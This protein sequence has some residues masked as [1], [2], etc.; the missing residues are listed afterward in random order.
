MLE[1]AP[2]RLRIWR[3]GLAVFHRRLD[4]VE[5]TAIRA[6]AR[7]EGFADV[8]AAAARIVGEEAA[9][10]AVLRVLRRWVGDG[11]IIAC[12]TFVRRAHL[13]E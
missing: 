11:M 10:P 1:R 5:L 8:C 6:V 9:A 3:E 13:N 2:T 12:E 4:D 7:G